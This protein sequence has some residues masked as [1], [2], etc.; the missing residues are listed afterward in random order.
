MT[1]H[2]FPSMA[3]TTLNEQDWH[4]DLFEVQLAHGLHLPKTAKIH[5]SARDQESAPGAFTVATL[6]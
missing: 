4:P 6:V 1:G 5:V 3:S 2:G